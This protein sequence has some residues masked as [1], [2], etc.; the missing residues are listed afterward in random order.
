MLW[1]TLYNANTLISIFLHKG[2]GIHYEDKALHLAVKHLQD[3]HVQFL[4]TFGMV[5]YNT[6]GASSRADVLNGYGILTIWSA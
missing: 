1:T 3:A 5:L 6:Y 2:L 4:C